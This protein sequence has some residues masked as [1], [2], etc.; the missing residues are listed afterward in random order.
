MFR[1]TVS[2]IILTLLLV[3]M[4]PLAF[5]I[6]PVKMESAAIIVAVIIVPDDYPTIQE[7]I[8]AAN[9][10]DTIL[11]R[12]GTYF[13]NVVVN[14]TVSLIG[15]N[16]DTTIIDGNEAGDCVHVTANYVKINEFTIRNGGDAY[17]SV[18]LS[19]NRNSIINCILNGS[20]CGVS[21]DDLCMYN[22]IA[23]NT[24][25]DNLNGIAGEGWF[26]SEIIGNT[27]ADNMLGMWM[28]PYTAYNIVSFNNIKNNR[29]NGLYMS[30]P[31]YCTFE[32]NNVTGNNL[33]GFDAGITISL[34]TPP[35]SGIPFSVGNK[36]FHN[37]IINNGKQID[38][39][40]EGVII[41]NDGYP[42]GGNYLS[43]YNGTD[44]YNGPYQ[45]ETGSDGMGDTSY[46]INSDNRDDYPLM[47]PYPSD[48]H[49]IGVT[50]IG[51][52]WETY[53]PPIILPLKTYVG[54]GFRLH[55]NVFVMNYG[56]YS[57][58]FNVTVYANTTVID[59]I[60]NVTLASRDSVVLNF[61]WDTT[62]VAKGNY[63]ISAYA[64]S[65]QGETDTADNLLTNGQVRVV[66]SGD[67]DG[68][69]IVTMKDIYTELVPRFMRKPGDLGYSANSDINDDGIINMQDIYTVIIHFM[70][71]E[72]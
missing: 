72:P 27:I 35:P 53:F 14:N 70:E 61:T 33:L 5:H 29:C 54:L 11:V 15:E 8:N 65:V 7:A 52:V 13:E 23:N 25:T 46:V 69:G 34:Q 56:A 50:Y 45:N 43:D 64:T 63:T 12:A 66:T 68:D 21:I 30:S 4:L 62:D 57:E 24:I 44:L 2:R 47:K 26:L 17:P 38:V 58:V 32:N 6:H 40:G 36:F 55:I 39:Y 18:R 49:D 67:I 51:K 16:K 59:T 19:S 10:D 31:A 48:S 9:P 28:G 1:K 3:S 71:T 41:W 42:S 22:V 60:T 37:N 20:G